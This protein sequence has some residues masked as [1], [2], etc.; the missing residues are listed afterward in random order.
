MYID[1]EVLDLGITEE[2]VE[3][4]V[5]WFRKKIEESTTKAVKIAEK[6]IEDDESQ[7]IHEEKHLM[8]SF[9]QHHKEVAEKLKE[10]GEWADKFRM[11][12]AVFACSEM[13][14]FIKERFFHQLAEDMFGKMQ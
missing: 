13:T 12:V 14:K 3:I 10:T 2:D 5:E 6:I 8:K 1:L 11:V 4:V 9:S 7:D